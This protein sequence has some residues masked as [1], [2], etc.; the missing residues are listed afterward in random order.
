MFQGET[1]LARTL[2]NFPEPFAA[3]LL[4][5]NRSPGATVPGVEVV[6][7]LRP[8][9][10]GPLAA[11]E[12]L[13]QACPTTWLLT[14]PVDVRDWP[15]DLVAKLLREAGPGSIGYAVADADG[16]QPLV[17]IWNAGALRISVVSALDA[18]ELAAHRWLAAQTLPAVDIAPFRLGNLNSAADFADATR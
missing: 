4:S 8:G 15:P 2:R 7:D 17:G 12:A 11:L 13:F 10:P 9:H 18:G 1:L 3:R 6:P 16:L 5:Y 14:V